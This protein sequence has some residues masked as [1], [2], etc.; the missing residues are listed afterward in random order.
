[1]D[2]FGLKIKNHSKYSAYVLHLHKVCII[3]IIWLEHTVGTS[4]T[5]HEHTLKRSLH[6]SGTSRGDVPGLDAPE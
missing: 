4:R 1:M 3:I 2:I 5:V 6:A